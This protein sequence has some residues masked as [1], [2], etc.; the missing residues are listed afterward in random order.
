MAMNPS[1]PK[2][3]GRKG[4][5][6][7]ALG[8]WSASQASYSKGLEK[9]PSDAS[10]Q[11]G[12]A[13]A[14][15]AEAAHHAAV[16]REREAAARPP[17]ATEDDLMDGF[18]SEL[19]SEADA[20]AEAQRQKEAAQRA[21]RNQAEKTEVYTKQSLGS[22]EEQ[23]QRLSAENY[24]FRNLNPY[25]VLELDIDATEEDIRCER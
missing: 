2:G 16:K 3:W 7:V 15:M 5:A 4:A 6:E 23:I 24:A 21:E 13:A 25:W 11:Q 19:S 14:K 12:L 1:W 18:F 22:S 8:R 9:V 17:P 10:L 20:R